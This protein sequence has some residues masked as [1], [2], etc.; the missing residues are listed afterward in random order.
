MTEVPAVPAE[1]DEPGAEGEPGGEGG[2]QRYR[3]VVRKRGARRRRRRRWLRVVLLV[4]ALVVVAGGAMVADGY[5]QAYRLGKQVEAA[6]PKLEAARA[7][8]SRGSTQSEA[9][10]TAAHQAVADLQARLAGERF[11][12]GWTGVLPFLGRP[13]DAVRLG[14]LAAGEGDAALSLGRDLYGQVLGSG[15]GASPLLHDGVVDLKLIEELTPKVEALVGHLETGDRYLRAIPHIPF[16]QRLDSLKATALAQSAEALRLGHRI[17]TGVKLLPGFFGADGPKNYFLALQNNADQRATGG[18][19][20]GYGIV[21]IDHGRMDLVRGG[22]ISSLSQGQAFHVSAPRP[23]RWYLRHASVPPRIDN[24]VNYTP[25]FPVVAATWAKQVSRAADL[26]IDGVIAVDPVAVSGLLR[27]QPPIHIG[28]FPDPI[29]SHNLV[30]VTEH[31]Q[32]SLGHSAQVVFTTQLVRAAFQVLTSPRNVPL[33]TKELTTALT[34]KRIQL[35]SSDSDLQG[36]LAELGWDGALKQP[37]GDYLFLVDEKRLSNKVDFYTRQSIRYTIKLDPAGTGEA[38][39]RVRLTNDTPPG[40][41]S[42]ITGL[43][44]PY[45]LNVAMLN[46]YVPAGAAD[47]SVEPDVPVKFKTRPKAFLTHTE[48]QSW[49]VLTKTV[50]AWPDNPADVTFHYSLPHVVQATPA[51][52]VYRLTIQHQ[53]LANPAEITVNVLLPPGVKVTASDPG[54]KVSGDVATFHTILTRDITTTLTYK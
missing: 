54:W 36:L 52:E 9:P 47:A 16:V 24:G 8:L 26:R 7:Q 39:A 51:G 35:W 22:G 10:F 3:T 23:I 33:M 44:K 32:Y 31:D 28:S 45:G 42:Y 50:E 40:E 25:D 5:W 34:E 19:S 14:A 29:T 53:P 6:L 4:A 27:D 41:P 38:S 21:R 2:P 1:Q 49:L 37:D 48:S 30:Q 18:A 15:P 43:W 13:V 17:E 20:L 12:F 11:T 46:L